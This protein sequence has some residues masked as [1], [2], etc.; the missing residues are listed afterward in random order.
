MNPLPSNLIEI[1]NISFTRRERR[2][3]SDINMTV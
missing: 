2:I 1:Q 3:F